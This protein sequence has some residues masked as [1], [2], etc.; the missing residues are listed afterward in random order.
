MPTAVP[1]MPI[2]T[3]IMIGVVPQ[4][5]EFEEPLWVAP[6]IAYN[7]TNSDMKLL[8]HLQTCL[9]SNCGQAVEVQTWYI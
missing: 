2:T 1:I 9:Y 5:Q 6:E 8:V 7:N 3:P 4:V